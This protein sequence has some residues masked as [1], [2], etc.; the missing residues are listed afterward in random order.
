MAELLPAH[1]EHGSRGILD[2]V[3]C[4]KTLVSERVLLDDHLVVGP[5][6][7]WVCCRSG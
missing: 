3:A 5:C 7:S 4:G 2:A 1:H 6:F